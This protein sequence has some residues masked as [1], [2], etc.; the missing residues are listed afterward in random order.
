MPADCHRRPVRRGHRMAVVR[1]GVDGRVH[2]AVLPDPRAG[3]A[4]MRRPPWHR[5]SLSAGMARHPHTTL[6]RACATG[7][8]P[9]P[10]IEAAPAG[11]DASSSGSPARSPEYTTRSRPRHGR[12]NCTN[13]TTGGATCSRN[14]PMPRTRP[15]TPR[16]RTGMVV[17][18]PA[19]ATLLPQAGIAARIGIPV[20]IPR[21]RTRIRRPRS[22]HHQ[23]PRGRNQRADQTHAR[24]SPR[25]SRTTPRP[26][27]RMGMLHEERQAGPLPLRHTG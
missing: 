23:P 27:V 9:R 12:C 11:G 16:H 7:F 3:R 2:R 10:D 15:G 25:P 8:T 18:A 1:A 20:R 19:P 13:G 5:E 4:G 24:Q 6:P 21:S 22:V 14:A 26:R 17:D